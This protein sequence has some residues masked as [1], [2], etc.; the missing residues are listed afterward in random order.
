MQLD[1]TVTGPLDP[2]R[3]RD[4]VHTVVNRHPNLAA[5]FC[6]RFDQ[7]VQII[8]ADPKQPGNT[9]NSTPMSTS[10]SSRCAPPSA[11]RS[12]TSP[13]SRPSGWR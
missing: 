3:L 5:R 6:Q 9:S 10:R 13:S 12:A 4:A 2:H 1:I 7:P 8:P 11:P